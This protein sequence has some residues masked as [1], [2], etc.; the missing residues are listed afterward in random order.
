[1]GIP[2]VGYVIFVMLAYFLASIICYVAV[3]RMNA[4][5]DAHRQIPL[6]KAFLYALAWTPMIIMCFLLVLNLLAGDK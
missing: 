5:R 6:L 2:L 4:K 1:M 3:L